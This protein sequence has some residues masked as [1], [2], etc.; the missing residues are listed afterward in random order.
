MSAAAS[1]RAEFVVIGLDH[2]TA[3]VDLR[4]QLAYAE[5]EIPSALRRATRGADPLLE[6]AAIVSTC[7]R[8]ELYGVARSR[9]DQLQL[10]SFLAD[11]NGLDRSGLERVVYVHRGEHVARH[12]AETAAGMRSMVLGETQI[13]GQIRTAMVRALDAGTAG[14]ELRRL[15][16]WAVAA[17]RRVRAD[18]AIGRGALSVPY[19]GV[20][21]ARSRLGTLSESTALLIGT[22]QAGELAARQLAQRQA[23][24]I[25]FAG[26]DRSRVRA[27]ARAYDGC[28]V[29]R[30]RLDAAL[31]ASDLIITATG[32]PPPLIG[33]GRLQRALLHRPS[34]AVPLLLVDISVPR[35]IDPAVRA[36]RGAELYTVDDLLVGIERA[37]S[38]RRSALPAAQAVVACEVTRF[39]DWVSRR[40][41]AKASRARPNRRARGPAAPRQG[42]RPGPHG[43]DVDLASPRVQRERHSRHQTERAAS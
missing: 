29:P 9:P 35:V 28:T 12:I 14:A 40:E 41:A 22:G 13:Q 20:E 18:T 5:A 2:T 31:A 30:T 11:P 6:Q 15:F 1:S 25:L 43:R 23:R 34:G 42:G 33:A 10:C 39:A 4:E 21:L 17:G 16:D 3:G 8:V 19:A 26:R 36:L 24:R 37:L 32:A 38:R 27:L 7:N